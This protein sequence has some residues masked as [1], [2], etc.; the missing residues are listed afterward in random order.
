MNYWQTP[1]IPHKG[2]QHQ[3]C[4]DTEANDENE[5]WHTCQMCGMEKV[6]YVHVL[7]HDQY[8]EIEVG[9]VCASKMTQDYVGPKAAE[10]AARNRSTRRSTWLTR[11]WIETPK[12]YRLTK[13]PF[14]VL[15]YSAGPAWKVMV[16]DDDRKIWGKKR[17]ES[18]DKA[19]LA[20]FDYVDRQ[21]S[22]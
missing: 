4:Y 22:S 18:I 14:S 15:V 16:S 3:S 13:G 12:G 8:G 19:K 5:A 9:C 11:K 1:G 17:F 21:M 10:T 6:R 7:T 20:A 2:W